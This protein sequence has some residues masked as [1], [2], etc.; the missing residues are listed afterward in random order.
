MRE[1]FVTMLFDARGGGEPGAM[2]EHQ[3]AP[4]SGSRLSLTAL[5]WDAI[6]PYNPVLEHEATGDRVSIHDDEETLAYARN[7]IALVRQ[8]AWSQWNDSAE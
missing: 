8:L 5:P 6:D 2:S 4:A 1:D 7:Q 3:P